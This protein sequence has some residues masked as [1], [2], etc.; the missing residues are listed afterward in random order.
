MGEWSSERSWV[1]NKLKAEIVTQAKG[2]EKGDEIEAQQ[3]P[4]IREASG[5]DPVGYAR[6]TLVAMGNAAAFVYDL[7]DGWEQ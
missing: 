4:Q 3:D 6:I 5:C 2:V 7:Q 1:T